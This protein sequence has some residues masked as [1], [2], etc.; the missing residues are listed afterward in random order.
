MGTD[1]NPT[2]RDPVA[3]LQKDRWYAGN[4][5][6]GEVGQTH[7]VEYGVVGW[8]KFKGDELEELPS[9]YRL[10]NMRLSKEQTG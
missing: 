8:G 2:W 7:Y 4:L 1:D 5:L 9:D 10:L 3:P 6:D